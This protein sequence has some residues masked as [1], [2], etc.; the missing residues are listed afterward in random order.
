MN[1]KKIKRISCVL[2]LVLTLIIG[3]FPPVHVEAKG[4]LKETIKK[5]EGKLGR[6]ENTHVEHFEPS[7]ELREY[8]KNQIDFNHPTKT[9]EFGDGEYNLPSNQQAKE[10]IIKAAAEMQPGVI[11]YGD[12]DFA[13]RMIK[14]IIFNASYGSY[15]K[16]ITKWDIS[17]ELIDPSRDIYMHI[18]RFEYRVPK[19][20]AMEMENRITLIAENIE[21]WA[22]SFEIPDKIIQKNHLTPEAVSDLK[23]VMLLHD[24]ILKNVKPYY[25]DTKNSDTYIGNSK[26]EVHALNSA[27]FEGK[28]VC[29]GFQIMFDRIANRLGLDSRI[30]RGSKQI[31]LDYNEAYQ[32]DYIAGMTETIKSAGR[33][34]RWGIESGG[35]NHGWNQV[36][37]GDKWY[38]IDMAGDAVNTHIGYPADDNPERIIVINPSKYS[39]GYFLKTDAQMA[40]PKRELGVV[41]PDKEII[42]DLITYRVWIGNENYKTATEPL[43]LRG[44]VYDFNGANAALDWEFEKTYP[45]GRIYFP[46]KGKIDFKNTDADYQPQT[47][48]EIVAPTYNENSNPLKIA[49]GH[50]SADAAILSSGLRA[51]EFVDGKL[52]YSGVWEYGKINILDLKHGDSSQT[53]DFLS[54]ATEIGK[55]IEL[56]A[57]IPSN[58]DISRKLLFR[59][60]DE[61]EFKSKVNIQLKENASD[62]L[63]IPQHLRNTN[64]SYVDGEGRKKKIKEIDSAIKNSIIAEEDGVVTDGTAIADGNIKFRWSKKGITDT[65]VAIDAPSKD[66]DGLIRTVLVK[67]SDGRW[68]SKDFKVI[69]TKVAKPAAGRIT[70][71]KDTFEKSVNDTLKVRQN[72]YTY[73][74]YRFKAQISVFEVYS[75]GLE[76]QRQPKIYLLDNETGE[77][78]YFIEKNSAGNFLAKDENGNFTKKVEDFDVEKLLVTEG[79]Y[80]FLFSL[81]LPQDEEAVTHVFR[82][83]VYDEAK[84]LEEEKARAKE[85]VNKSLVFEEDKLKEAIE[86]IEASKTLDNLSQTME[87]FHQFIKEAQEAKKAEESKKLEEAKALTLEQVKAIEGISEEKLNEVTGWITEAEDIAKLQQIVEDLKKFVEDL[88]NKEL[89]KEKMSDSVDRAKEEVD[90]MLKETEEAKKLAEGKKLEEAKTLALEE[91]KAIEGMNAEQANEFVNRIHEAE[92]ME[93][94][95][96]IMEDF[97]I[98]AQEVLKKQLLDAKEKAKETVSALSDIAKEE[99]DT[100]LLS[101]ENAGSMGELQNILSEVYNKGKE[102]PSNQVSQDENS[103]KNGVV[104]SK[105]E[106]QANQDSVETVINHNDSNRFGGSKDALIYKAVVTNNQIKA[107]QAR[108]TSVEENQ[109]V[110]AGNSVKEGPISSEVSNKKAEESQMTADTSD[111]KAEE[112]QMIADTS[113]DKAKER[114]VEADLENSRVDTPSKGRNNSLIY[115]VAVAG[116]AIVSGGIFALI[117]L[118]L[119]KK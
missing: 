17:S 57:Y 6:V 21:K 76:K 27:M 43:D 2:F 84:K 95:Q 102:Q 26:S 51:V 41:D 5:L 13:D 22:N 25:E 19:N 53:E 16:H 100:L 92:D 86:E 65:N 29:Q 68:T 52:N 54:K 78:K 48:Y 61:S 9:P 114:Q 24:Y 44:V 116:L 34:V 105:E 108:D 96:Q 110:I 91:V 101:L 106:G 72:I 31:A 77:P 33:D 47:R 82:L 20:H 81:H 117:K 10:Y 18:M 59:V 88:A 112:S 49:S 109:T 89:E 46:E 99:L 85:E 80:Q 93:K 30:I 94:V 56:T 71:E 115:L 14:S 90:K 37:I 39:Y 97:Q 40:K 118:L 111:D 73:L 87:K 64:N 58:Q 35:A 75:G 38:H 4:N 50:S 119:A 15:L 3:V 11:L 113:D 7:K 103:G 28:T 1:C 107:E 55:D 63:E 12:K 98:F 42:G 79:Y 32:K 45:L 69:M 66:Q 70:Y 83:T 8:M 74:H 104:E 36:K 23:K 60:S 67:G 62:I